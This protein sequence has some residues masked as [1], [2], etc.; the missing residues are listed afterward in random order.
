MKV[1]LG[2]ELWVFVCL[3]VCGPGSYKDETEKEEVFRNNLDDC[4][5]LE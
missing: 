1:K 3:C 4:R 2:H 5:V